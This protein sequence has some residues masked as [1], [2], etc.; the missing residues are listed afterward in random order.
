MEE[1][2]YQIIRG[3][4]AGVVPV[5]IYSICQLAGLTPKGMVF[6]D[7]L[8][9]TTIVLFTLVYPTSQFF[10]CLIFEPLELFIKHKLKYPNPE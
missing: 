4:V 2:K 5:T 7:L 6:F 9:W 10:L 8:P 1:L 3:I